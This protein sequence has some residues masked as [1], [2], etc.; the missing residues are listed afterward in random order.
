MPCLIYIARIKSLSKE[1]AQGLQCA[2]FHAK[3][4]KPGDITED[5]CLLVMTSEAVLAETVL[6]SLQPEGNGTETG[7]PAAPDMK[8][9][10]GSQAAIWNR[11]KTAIAKESPANSEQVSRMASTV[12][13]EA[14]EL[15]V[16]RAEVGRRAVANVQRKSASEKGRIWPSQNSVVSSV[17]VSRDTKKICS[18]EKWYYGLIRNPWSTALAMIVLAMVYRG[19]TLPSTTG[20]SIG[21]KANYSTRSDSDSGNSLLNASELPIRTVHQSNPALILSSAEPP[22]A[23][24][25][26]RQHLSDDDFVAQ[27]FTN[28]FRLHA[29][30]SAT[31]QN[32]ELKHP[33]SGLKRKRIVVD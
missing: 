24:E 7:P 17:E 30:S 21:R 11:I 28:H 18:K 19:L 8:K 16:I 1:L 23:A 13:P 31:Q 3:Y 5:E 15:G 22:K 27:D 4:F 9:Q 6:A 26:V 12:E 10:L 29:Q 32:T 14:I 20:A 25:G 2:G 33:Q